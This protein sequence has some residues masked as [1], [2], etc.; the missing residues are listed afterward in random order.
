MK[1]TSNDALTRLKKLNLA[2]AAPA[3]LPPTQE[4]VNAEE[5]TK[6]KDR[7]TDPEVPVERTVRPTRKRRSGK[8]SP[9]E[10]ATKPEGRRKP[11]SKGSP[12]AIVTAYLDPLHVEVLVDLRSRYGTRSLSVPSANLLLKVALRLVKDLKPSDAQVL[13]AFE[14]ESM[15]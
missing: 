1:L 8:D 14:A 6:S 15:G 2:G 13:A 7:T 11:H 5:A 10:E 3:E 12:A 9:P 4:A